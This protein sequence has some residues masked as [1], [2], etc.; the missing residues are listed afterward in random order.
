MCYK[1]KCE[2]CNKW[3]WGGCGNHISQALKGIAEKDLC[4]CKIK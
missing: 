4:K 1:R 2:K 3:A